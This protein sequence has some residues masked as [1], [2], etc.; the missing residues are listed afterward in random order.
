MIDI[1]LR[2][3]FIGYKEKDISG[4]LEKIVFLE[5]LYRGYKIHIGKLNGKEIDFIALKDDNKIYFQV[6]YLLADNNVTDREFS[7]LREIKDNYRKIVLSLDKYYP[8]NTE[9]IEW[10]NLIEFLVG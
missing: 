10:M 9:G 5:L 2:H 3:G 6:T 4:L 1:G 7:P 8:A